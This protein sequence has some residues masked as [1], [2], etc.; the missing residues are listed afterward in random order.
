MPGDRNEFAELRGRIFDLLDQ[1]NHMD[2][3]S[4]EAAADKL[5]TK[6]H[7]LRCR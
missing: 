7:Q 5:S 1:R 2:T 3:E 6:A 4:F